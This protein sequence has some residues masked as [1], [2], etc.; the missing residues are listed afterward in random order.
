MST[1]IYPYHG[2]DCLHVLRS[3]FGS[4]LPDRRNG[5]ISTLVR[6]MAVHLSFTARTTLAH[7]QDEHRLHTT[8]NLIQLTSVPVSIEGPVHDDPRSPSK[9]RNRGVGR[10]NSNQFFL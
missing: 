3:P 2:S 9:C 8:A 10:M 7:A 1:S 4:L 6:Y 5:L